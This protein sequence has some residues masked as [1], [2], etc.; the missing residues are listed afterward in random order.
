[1]IE[2][3]K[4]GP[5]AIGIDGSSRMFRFYSRGVITSI[6]CGAKLNHAVLLV[7]YGQ[8]GNMP[9]WVIKNSWGLSWGEKG[10]ARILRDELPGGLGVC[11]V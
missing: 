2:R 1:M 4:E 11:G 10:Y 9:Y 3:L 8:R 7:G 6:N 5:I